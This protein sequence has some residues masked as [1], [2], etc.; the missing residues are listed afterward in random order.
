MHAAGIA[1]GMTRREKM[2]ATLFKSNYRNKAHWRILLSDDWA[3]LTP[4]SD[5][6]EILPYISRRSAH[7]ESTET[8]LDIFYIGPFALIYARLLD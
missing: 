4:W 8:K 5:E 3:S 2:P 7:T 1:A 6:G